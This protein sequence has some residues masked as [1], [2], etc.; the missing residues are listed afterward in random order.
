[1]NYCNRTWMEISSAAAADNFNK[2]KAIS[3]DKKIF[4]VVKANG[5]GHGAPEIS[6]LFESLGVDGFAVSNIFEALELR[7]CG[8]K[9][10]ILIL[11]YTPFEHADVLIKNN[12]SQTVYSFDY[13]KKLNSFAK[14]AGGKISCHIKLDT[15]MSRLGF[16]AKS[17]LSDTAKEELKECFCFE[18]LEYDGVFTH[19]ST[20][21]SQE[22]N[23]IEFCN[24]QYDNF[25]KSISELKEIGFS[26]KYIHCDNSAATL[27]RDDEFTNL[28]RPG[29]ILYGYYPS[30][31]I[32][33]EIELTPVLSLKSVVSMVKEIDTGDTVSYGRVFKADR[34]MKIATVP[35][36]YADGYPRY[37]SDKGFALIKGTKVPIIGRICMDQ[38]MLDVSDIENIKI[39]D[40]VTLIGRDGNEKITADD[41]A[42]LGNTI[43]Y[44]II[45]GF[46]PRVERE[47][48]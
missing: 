8:I 27:K 31:D 20:A 4:A 18:N 38:M 16:N 13:A 6:K 10:E 25:K 30:A 5:Y 39:G 22:E 29:I 35:V 33:K 42:K 2:I 21:D 17:G 9:K 19:F 12:I 1:M 23:D 34:K 41:I 45:C 46:T 43:C 37:L 36:G 32:K 3:K 11:G 15:G 48:L 28:I 7:E 44:E 24:K 26:F 47:Y 14:S 40:V